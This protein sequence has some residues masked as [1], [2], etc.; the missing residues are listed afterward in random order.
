LRKTQHGYLLLRRLESIKEERTEKTRKRNRRIEERTE[1][2][3]KEVGKRKV[4]Y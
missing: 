4:A 3:Q 2:E 1:V